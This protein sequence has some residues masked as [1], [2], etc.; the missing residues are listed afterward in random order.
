MIS[1]SLCKNHLHRRP[2]KKLEHIV[3]SHQSEPECG[4]AVYPATAE[5]VLVSLAN[6]AGARMDMVHQQ[7]KKAVPT[8]TFSDFVPGLETRLYARALTKVE[9]NDKGKRRLVV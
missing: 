2:R 1:R 3:L 4:A 6:N 8:Q 5:A 7:L 9:K